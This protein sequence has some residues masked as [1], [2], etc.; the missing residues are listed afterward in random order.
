MTGLQ[1]GE[2]GQF[3]HFGREAG[4]LVVAKVDFL[5]SYKKKLFSGE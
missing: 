1:Q 3:F 2:G 4:K 5:G